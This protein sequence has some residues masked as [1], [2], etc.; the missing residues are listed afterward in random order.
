MV[1]FYD[2][3]LR[4]TFSLKDSEVKGMFQIK[5]ELCRSS[6]KIILIQRSVCKNKTKQKMWK[7]T[8]KATL[9]SLNFFF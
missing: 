6:Q 3:D 8:E 5:Y 1:P 2:L 7:S 9:M 4:T